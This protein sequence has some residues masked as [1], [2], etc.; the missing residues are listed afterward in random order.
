MAYTAKQLSMAWTAVHN[1]VEPDAATLAAL[2]L[3]TNASFSD[4]D[5]LGYV[6]RRR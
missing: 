1:G 5:A 4:Q 6:V 2:Q 3:R